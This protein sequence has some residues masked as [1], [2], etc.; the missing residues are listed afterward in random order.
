MILEGGNSS[1]GGSL[2][3]LSTIP[4]PFVGSSSRC[5]RQK[6]SSPVLGWGNWVVG[7][8]ADPKEARRMIHD[9]TLRVKP[10]KGLA[11]RREEQTKVTRA[12]IEAK[13]KVKTLQE[14]SVSATSFVWD[15]AMDQICLVHLDKDLS[16][17][18]LDGFTEDGVRQLEEC[19]ESIT[20]FT[21]PISGVYE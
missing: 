18:P 11:K 14:Y 19:D 8:M 1:S 7:N 4:P 13:G 10:I 20:K 17:M 3:V 6:R 12:L 16:R 21:S 15:N 2:N 9:A 5:Y